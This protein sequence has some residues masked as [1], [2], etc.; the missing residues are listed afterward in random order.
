[1]NQKLAELIKF[2]KALENVYNTLAELEIN[3][4]IESEEYQENVDY[5]DMIK[6]VIDKKV[7]ALDLDEE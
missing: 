3:G 4:Q 2:N 1:M 5:L 6:E 7:R